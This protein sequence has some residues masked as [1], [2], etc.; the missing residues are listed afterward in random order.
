MTFFFKKIKDRVLDF[1]VY[2]SIYD[3]ATRVG[4][5]VFFAATGT[6]MFYL[7]FSWLLF[8]WTRAAR[9]TKPIKPWIFYLAFIIYFIVLISF[10]IAFEIELF[11]SPRTG[12]PPPNQIE[13]NT[14]AF[15][16]ENEEI[17][18]NTTVYWLYYTLLYIAAI[19]SFIVSLT[20]FINTIIIFKTIPDKKDWKIRRVKKIEQKDLHIIQLTF[21]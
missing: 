5:E 17:E 8:I 4:V 12:V 19:V 14:L 16:Q 2:L 18:K 1:A 9:P 11:L 7:T 3:S 15:E 20:F 6:L 10:L 21:F 13:S